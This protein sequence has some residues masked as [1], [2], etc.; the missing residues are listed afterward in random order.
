MT[1]NRMHC[2]PSYFYSM[3]VSSRGPFHGKSYEQILFLSYLRLV[4]LKFHL[5]EFHFN[6]KILNTRNSYYSEP[7]LDSVIPIVIIYHK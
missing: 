5:F 3:F 6:N 7:E 4:T 2:F 1:K